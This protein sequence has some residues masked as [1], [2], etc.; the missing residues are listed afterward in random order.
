MIVVAEENLIRIFCSNSLRRYKLIH[1][2]AVIFKS[3]YG[4]RFHEYL[5]FTITDDVGKLHIWQL[6]QTGWC[7]SLIPG[8]ECHSEYE[9]NSDSTI[10]LIRYIYYVTIYEY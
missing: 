1:K 7:H 9:L 4:I 10:L 2:L 8:M 6:S 5:T 3:Y